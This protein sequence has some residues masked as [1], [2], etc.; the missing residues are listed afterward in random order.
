M[1]QS[2]LVQQQ[3]ISLC[4]GHTRVNCS[5]NMSFYYLLKQSPLLLESTTYLSLR[6]W[7]MALGVGSVTTALCPLNGKNNNT[8]KH[9]YGLCRRNGT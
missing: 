4:I 9:P 1:I 2:E 8:L 3:V 7:V 5:V 6:S